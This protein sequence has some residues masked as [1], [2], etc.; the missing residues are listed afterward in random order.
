MWYSTSPRTVADAAAHTLLYSTHDFQG[1]RRGQTQ[2]TFI[3]YLLPS[4][5][6]AGQKLGR[7]RCINKYY[8]Y[9][10]KANATN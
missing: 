4:K 5:I 9:K 7:A 1:G 2:K 3:L 8:I 10:L 6:F